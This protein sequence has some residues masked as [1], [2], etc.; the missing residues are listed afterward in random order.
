MGVSTRQRQKSF[1]NNLE[2]F[3]L[4]VLFGMDES[5]DAD[6][7]GT[8]SFCTPRSAGAKGRKGLASVS[9]FYAVC[10]SAFWQAVARV[11]DNLCGYCLCGRTYRGYY[12]IQQQT[13]L[14]PRSALDDG[15]MPTLA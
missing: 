5:D 6:I 8:K 7:Q 15:P 12:A 4:A 10:D 13:V 9:S 14:L 3:L 1:I 11:F 2:A